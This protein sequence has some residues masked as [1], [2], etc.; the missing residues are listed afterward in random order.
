M[1]VGL[2]CHIE[3]DVDFSFVDSHTE[4]SSVGCFRHTPMPVLEVVDV[5]N[6]AK[7][8]RF[9][10][11]PDGNA[12]FRLEHQRDVVA[13]ESAANASRLVHAACG[14][15]HLKWFLFAEHRVAIELVGKAELFIDGD[16]MSP[17]EVDG[18]HPI[19]AA[20]RWFVIQHPAFEEH[21]LM[22]V[23]HL[24]A[25]VVR[26]HQ[27][28][29]GGQRPLHPLQGTLQRNPLHHLRRRVRRSG[30]PRESRCSHAP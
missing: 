27:S 25:R 20:K 4:S 8:C 22:R 3:A 24:V 13:P 30:F 9:Q 2:S 16:E 6:R 15:Q 11:A 17:I 1:E 23:V 19:G 10:E 12:K 18:S 26:H 28:Q 29:V 5:G 14:R 21:A 7:D